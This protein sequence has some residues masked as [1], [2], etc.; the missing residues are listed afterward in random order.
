MR[1]GMMS[2]P[3]T[4]TEIMLFATRL[5]RET[6]V[7]SITADEGVHRSTYG[8]VFK[9]A[10]QVA[11][12]LGRLGVD[13]GNRVAT[14]AWNDHRHLE[15]YYGVSCSGAVLHTINPRLF[16]EQLAYIIN[17]ADD[18]VIFFD[19]MFLPLM[20]GLSDKLSSVSHFVVL[21]SKNKMPE[22][23]LL[24]LHC[25]EDLISQDCSPYSWP[26]LDETTASALCYTSGTTG[27]PKGVLYDH[28][29]TVLHAYGSCMANVLGLS[30]HDVVMPV[31]PN[32]FM[33][34]AWGKL[35]IH[36][37]SLDRR[38]CLPGP[39]MADG[40]TLH[41]LIENE[42]VTIALGVP[43]VWLELLAYLKETGKDHRYVK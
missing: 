42:G 16:P 21:T 22:S 38:L 2:T 33:W 11:H 3:L 18:R 20:E 19:P 27:N 31:V 6:E 41:S 26:A 25:Y 5:Y 36:V 35:L 13:P 23:S 4:I 39:K 24:T 29:S 8:T 34:N 43:T 14:L 15:L 37:L 28:R 12:A 9:R 7:I 10:N 30:H 32:V 17:H 1:G 40:E